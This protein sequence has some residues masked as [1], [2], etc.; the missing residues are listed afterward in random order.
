MPDHFFAHCTV[1][2]TEKCGVNNCEKLHHKVLHNK[3]FH[4]E[5]ILLQCQ[6]GEE[7]NLLTEIYANYDN[8]NEI[9]KDYAIKSM[10][11]FLL[12][13]G[14]KIP[15]N[16]IIDSG[17]NTS[18]ID[19]KLVKQ[20]NIKASTP[21]FT[22]RVKY[23]STHVQ[24]T[25]AGYD[26]QF[27][28][29]DGQNSQF[30]RAYRVKNFKSHVPNWSEVC[31]SH[32]YLKDIKL[33]KTDDNV[34]RILLGT[35]CE[36]LF[37]S[38]ETRAAKNDGPMA[39]KNILGWSFLGRCTPNVLSKNM[40]KCFKMQDIKDEKPIKRKSYDAELNDLVKR[41]LDIEDWNLKENDLPLSKKFKG[42]PKPVHLW[43]ES[44]HLG[45]DRMEIE[46]ISSTIDKH[47][48]A[49]IP[50]KDGYE[51]KLKNNFEAVRKRQETTLSEAALKRKGITLQQ[52]QEIFD[53]Y[54]AKRY[55]KE[56]PQSQ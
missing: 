43:T 47:F 21:D 17:S 38:Y 37:K 24:F 23:V 52:I 12:V 9:K 13:D 49:R 6:S 41:S 45:Y 53:G 5:E 31:D 10:T 51:E 1:K 14:E 22:R 20:L 56:I 44:E 33:P 4:A 8:F 35:D 2:P 36:S 42:G 39:D 30:V 48:V 3:T 19:E 40:P 32:D 27:T 18:N 15:V 25:S 46:H 54:L 16:V 11:C 34:A 50:W 55:I 7:C 29:Q 26:L 28:S